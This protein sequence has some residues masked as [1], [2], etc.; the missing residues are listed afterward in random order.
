[1]KGENVPHCELTGSFFSWY[2]SWPHCSGYW[3]SRT[4]NMAYVTIHCN[5]IPFL[6]SSHYWAPC[7]F[8]TQYLHIFSSSLENMVL[9]TDMFTAEKSV[10]LCARGSLSEINK[11]NCVWNIV[12]VIASTTLWFKHGICGADKSVQVSSTS[13]CPVFQIWLM[14][15]SWCHV[16]G[17]SQL[18]LIFFHWKH[19]QTE[20]VVLY[21][22]TGLQITE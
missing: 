10:H 7:L 21:I 6:K 2:I 16:F 18:Y 11:L 3:M 4:N 5:K 19:V 17:V 1:M 22:C 15:E 8:S 14:L 20:W 12:T 9:F 13:P